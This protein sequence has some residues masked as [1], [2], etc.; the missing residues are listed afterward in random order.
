MKNFVRTAKIVTVTL[1]LALA[2]NIQ[3]TAQPMEPHHPQMVP[4]SAQIVRMVN[5]LSAQLK[6]TP[7]QKATI[8]KLHFEHFAQVKAMMEQSRA[9]HEKERAAME[10]SRLKFEE[11]V[12]AQLTDAQKAELEKFR[13]SHRP[14][15]REHQ[16]SEGPQMGEPRNNDRPQ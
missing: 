14:P 7:E 1:L 10:A 12:N 4:D 3:L 9:Q 2:T 5:D 6:L 11:A 16:S 15:M 13:Q 8:T